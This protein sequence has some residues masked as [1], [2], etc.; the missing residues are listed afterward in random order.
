MYT[1]FPALRPRDR[2]TRYRLHPVRTE[3]SLL[4]L[5]FRVCPILWSLYLFLFVVS[6][7]LFYARPSFV[8][9]RTLINPSVAKSR[10]LDDTFA[11]IEGVRNSLVT[12][13]K[14]LWST[15]K[16]G[17][18]ISLRRAFIHAAYTRRASRLGQRLYVQVSGEHCPKI[19]DNLH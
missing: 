12:R 16:I 5:P 4:F 15:N 11:R 8:N 6:P 1:R 13:A 7:L 3:G 19:R 2:I 14:H 18:Q 17:P 10:Y 9:D